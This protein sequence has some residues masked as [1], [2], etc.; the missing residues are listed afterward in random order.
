M[1]FGKQVDSNL[2]PLTDEHGKIIGALAVFK[3]VD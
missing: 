2:A 1:L 3:D